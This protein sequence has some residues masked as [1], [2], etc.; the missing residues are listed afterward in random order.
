MGYYAHNY[1][2]DTEVFCSQCNEHIL[3]DDVITLTQ[4]IGE[5][6]YRHN[7]KYVCEN[8]EQDILKE[9]IENCDCQWAEHRKLVPN[10]P[11]EE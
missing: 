10:P 2:E 11:D 9:E 1:W 4:M 7:W 8:C 3:E 5:K 6:I